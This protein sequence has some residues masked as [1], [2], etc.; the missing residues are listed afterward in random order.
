MQKRLVSIQDI[1]CL[2]KCSLTVA[3]PIISAAGIETCVIPTAVLSTHTGGFSGYTFRDLT[4]DI[5]KISEHWKQLN[6]KFDS[7]YTGYLGSIE[8]LKIVSDFFDNFKNDDTLIFI[9]PVMGD[10]GKLYKGFSFDFPKEMAKL[11]AKADVLTPNITEACLMTNVEYIEKGYDEKYIHHLLTKL[12]KLG[13]KK[14]L[15][16]GVCFNDE[17]LGSVSYDKESGEFFSYFNKKIP[18]VFHGTGDIFASTCVSAL[19]K[20]FSMEKA[21]KTSVDFTLDCI[22]T[23]YDTNSQEKWYGVEFERCIPKFIKYMDLL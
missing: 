23:T 13:A 21:I 15:L 4:N 20:G 18:Q 7:I 22:Q 19:T 17:K 9:D 5:P 6:L 1:S 12:S 8:Q 14:V 2:G 3:L 10:H 11:C 16:T